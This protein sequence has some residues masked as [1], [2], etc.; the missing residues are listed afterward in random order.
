METFSEH[1]SNPS[2]GNEPSPGERRGRSLWLRVVIGL[3]CVALVAAVP[4]YVHQQDLL[5]SQARA[6]ALDGVK[7]RDH[8]WYAAK[9]LGYVAVGIH[10]DDYTT[11]ALADTLAIERRGLFPGSATIVDVALAADGRTALISDAQEGYGIW[12]LQGKG[13]ESGRENLQA[14]RTGTLGAGSGPIALSSDG[15]RAVT[16]EDVSGGID[17]WDLGDPD[18]PSRTP[19]R[20]GDY[21]EQLLELSLTA[22][23]T[24]LF[25]GF[26]DGS[27]EIWNLGAGR[28]PRQLARRHEHASGVRI[29]SGTSDGKTLLTVSDDSAIFWS[30]TDPSRPTKLAELKSATLEPE[31]REWSSGALSADGKRAIIG[32]GVWDTTNPQSPTHL[33]DLSIIPEWATPVAISYDGSIAVTVDDEPSGPASSDPVIVWGLKDG[34]RPVSLATLRTP[35][36]ESWLVAMSKD[37]RTLA[38]GTRTGGAYS[39]LLPNLR[40]GFMED[41]CRESPPLPPV[42]GFWESVSTE[43]PPDV[44]GKRP[45]AICPLGGRSGK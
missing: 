41:A 30:M 2:T 28:K 14:T 20:K 10:S 34:Y 6:I 35:E 39:W 29:L 24:T 36:S 45:F 11:S 21:R 1:P 25:A 42:P 40:K 43:S 7:Q 8:D 3:V 31:V 23:G 44:L 4:I 13:P 33:G 38:V 37:G 5:V 22:D 26:E 9:L 12:Q 27:I 32:R 15:R 18:R 19:V 17:V 16:G